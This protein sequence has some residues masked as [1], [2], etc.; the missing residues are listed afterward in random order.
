MLAV[1]E[2]RSRPRALLLAA[3]ALPLFVACADSLQPFRAPDQ[4]GSTAPLPP[5]VSPGF[6]PLMQS[7]QIY[8]AEP[9]LD[10]VYSKYHGA[11]LA[12][13]FVLYDD[14]T[15]ALQFASGLFGTF[16]YGGRFTR[17]DSQITFIW[18]GWSAAGA[19]GAEGT[20]HGNSLTVAYNDIMQLT[21]FIDGTYRLSRPTP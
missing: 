10:D 18:K 4:G 3:C 11:R 7:G 21:D 8:V 9:S 20:L 1:R 16:E 19:W 6:A 12:S 2:K 17:A 14:S 15:F 13:R 5:L